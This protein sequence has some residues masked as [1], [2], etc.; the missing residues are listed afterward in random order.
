MQDGI[1]LFS[2][3]IY[4]VIRQWIY[5]LVM[6]IADKFQPFSGK[7]LVIKTVIQEDDGEYGCRAQNT[8]GHIEAVANIR[9]IRGT[10]PIFTDNA[11]EFPS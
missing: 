6:I 3:T 7:Q 5:I 2:K 9:V 8:G 4:T 10:P 11:L 1:D